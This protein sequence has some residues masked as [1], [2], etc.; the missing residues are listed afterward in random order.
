MHLESF[1]TNHYRFA[2]RDRMLGHPVNARPVNSSVYIP[3]AGVVMHLAVENGEVARILRI[4]YS[5]YW[6]MG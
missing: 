2:S 3:L 5:N 4:C 1:S 6:S